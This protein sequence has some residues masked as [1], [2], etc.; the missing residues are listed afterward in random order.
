MKNEIKN[1]RIFAENRTDR[2]GFDVFI[3]LSGHRYYLV[4]HRNNRYVYQVLK[5]GIS[6]SDLT[7]NKPYQL[8]THYGL[9]LHRR[10]S[11]KDSNSLRHLIKVIEYFIEEYEEEKQYA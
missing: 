5:D 6:L 9:E 3:S 11:V 10:T 4:F 7:R 2:K 1:V 8:Y